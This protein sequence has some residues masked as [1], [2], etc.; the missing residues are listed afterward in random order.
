LEMGR[1]VNR[2]QACVKADGNPEVIDSRD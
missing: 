2:T 1:L